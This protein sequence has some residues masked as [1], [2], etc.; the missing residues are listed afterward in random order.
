MRSF[1][2]EFREKILVEGMIAGHSSVQNP[3]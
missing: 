3:F 1:G 2:E